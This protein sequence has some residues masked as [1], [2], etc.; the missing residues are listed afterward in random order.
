MSAKPIAKTVAV[1][2]VVSGVAAAIPGTP[3]WATVGVGHEGAHTSIFPVDGIE[4]LSDLSP[5]Q[6]R[7]ARDRGQIGDIEGI[8]GR[9]F[10][11]VIRTEVPGEFPS[12]DITRSVDVAQVEPLIVEGPAEN[13][14]VKLAHRWLPTLFTSGICLA[15]GGYLLTDGRVPRKETRGLL[16]SDGEG[17]P[18]RDEY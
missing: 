6:I 16:F 9:A 7:S 1:P 2:E 13:A 5:P 15:W 12:D 3:T 10:A 14:V 11:E 4:L 18:R 8:S 17:G